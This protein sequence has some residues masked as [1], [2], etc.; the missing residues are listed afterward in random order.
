LWPGEQNHVVGQRH[1][2]L[3]QAVLHL[4]GIAASGI[5]AL[6]NDR[7]NSISPASARSGISDLFYTFD[8]FIYRGRR[9]ILVALETRRELLSGIA[10]ELKSHTP[11]VGSSDTLDPTPA[12]MISL[13]KAF[14]MMASSQS[15]ATP[16]TRS[17]GVPAG[18][19]V[20]GQQ[21]HM[22]S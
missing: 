13:V 5:I 20:Q 21:A 17:G 1:Q 2:L 6:D 16:V 3:R 12:E 9:L 15:G 7:R 10:A 22:R 19:Q 4:F 11:L 18:A 8:V 14:E